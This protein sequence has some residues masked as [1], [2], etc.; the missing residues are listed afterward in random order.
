[1]STN[2]SGLG[3][4]ELALDMLRAAAAKANVPCELDAVSAGDLLT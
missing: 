4:A 2:Y 1:M 3:T